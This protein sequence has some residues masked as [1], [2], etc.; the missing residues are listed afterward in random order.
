MQGGA[1]VNMY[2][3]LRKRMSFQNADSLSRLHQ[4]RSRCLVVK[5]DVETSIE[6]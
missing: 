2:S 5:V 4:A 6:N 1:P 3:S